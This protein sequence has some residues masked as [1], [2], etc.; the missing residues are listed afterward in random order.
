[1]IALEAVH[2]SSKSMWY[3]RVSYV[4]Q[5]PI[6]VMLHSQGGLLLLAQL[7][8]CSSSVMTY[9]PDLVLGTISRVSASGKERYPVRPTARVCS[10]L[11]TCQLGHHSRARPRPGCWRYTASWLPCTRLCA[12]TRRTASPYWT[13]PGGSTSLRHCC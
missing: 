4:Q 6:S 11:G 7:F 9:D 5:G 13:L 3:G 8:Q 12:D 1:M 2:Q 10:A